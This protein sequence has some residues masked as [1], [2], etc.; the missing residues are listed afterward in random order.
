MISLQITL[1]AVLLAISLGFLSHLVPQKIQA[2]DRLYAFRRNNHYP[3]SWKYYEKYIKRLKSINIT[4]SDQAI[5][6]TD[7]C[8]T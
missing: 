4:E 2:L 3:I 1:G 6:E 8:H 7:Q 5:S